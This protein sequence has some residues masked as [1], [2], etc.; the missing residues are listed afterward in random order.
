ME[1]AALLMA[2]HRIVAGIQIED[3]Q[4]GR[5]LMRLQEQDDE[6]PLDR[7]GVVADLVVPIQRRGRRMLEPV[8]GALAGERGAVGTPG[9]ELAR[10]VASTGSWRNS[11]WSSRSS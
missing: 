8:Q 9:L 6:Q 3:D 4:F 7:A 10:R 11:S 1:E 5:P 2:V